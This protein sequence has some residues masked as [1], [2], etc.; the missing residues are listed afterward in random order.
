MPHDPDQKFV[1]DV[2]SRKEIAQSIEPYA[3]T[4]QKVDPTDDR[5]T[6]EFCGEYANGLHHIISD[7]AG[8]SEDAQEEAQMVWAMQ[9][10]EKFDKEHSPI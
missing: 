2:I 9:M 3:E 8:M 4:C 10:A 6:D 5:L 7:T 1:I